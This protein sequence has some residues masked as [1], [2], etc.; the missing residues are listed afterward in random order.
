[1]RFLE[2]PNTC[3]WHLKRGIWKEPKEGKKKKWEENLTWFPC[4]FLLSRCPLPVTRYPLPVTPC[5]FLTIVASDPTTNNKHCITH[6]RVLIVSHC[7]I[8]CL[9]NSLLSSQTIHLEFSTRRKW[10]SMPTKGSKSHSQSRGTERIWRRYCIRRG[11]GV[12]GNA[13]VAED[14]RRKSRNGRL[15]ANRAR[16]GDNW[17]WWG[18]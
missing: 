3:W 12:V 8:L 10:T 5:T 15:L 14:S 17:L 9:T 11:R 2:C 6:I 13:K 1:M 4:S 16:F 18:K 7:F